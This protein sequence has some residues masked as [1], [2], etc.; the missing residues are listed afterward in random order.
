MFRNHLLKRVQWKCGESLCY[1]EIASLH[2]EKEICGQ[3]K[4]VE[5]NNLRNGVSI[6]KSEQVVPGTVQ[7]L[8]SWQVTKQVYKGS[9]LCHCIVTIL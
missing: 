6:G 7:D 5:R 1:K 8:F 4:S 9:V 3:P 2:K